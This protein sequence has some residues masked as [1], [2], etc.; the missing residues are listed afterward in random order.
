[1]S[2]KMKTEPFPYQAEEHA[3]SKD[4]EAWGVLW[5]QGCVDSETEYLTPSGWRRIDRYAGGPVGQW[6]PEDGKVTFVEPSEY[7]K[8]PCEKM[9]FIK[10]RYRLNQML[11]AEHRVPFYMNLKD[12][13]LTIAPMRDVYALLEGGKILGLPTNYT[14]KLRGEGCGESEAWLRLQTIVTLKGFQMGQKHGGNIYVYAKG[15]NSQR[16]KS[17]IEEAKANK[18]FCVEQMRMGDRF[19]IQDLIGEFDHH[20]WVKVNDRDRDIILDEAYN[21]CSSTWN[22]VYTRKKVNADFIQFLMSS[23]GVMTRMVTRAI[24][25]WFIREEPNV[26]RLRDYRKVTIR[27]V[28]WVGST[29]GFKYCFKV[30]TSFLLF[31]RGEVIF[32]SGNTGKSKVIVDCFGHNLY[33]GKVDAMVVIAPPGV[34]RNWVTDEI[35]R[36]LPDEI[37][38]ETMVRFYQ[39]KRAS[40]KWHQREMAELVAHKGPSILTMSYEA[41][42]TD[43]GKQV[44]WQMMSRR[45]CFAVLD[46]AQKIKSPKAKRTESIV[47]SGVY[48]AMRRIAT[49]TLG[50]EG[51]MDCFEPINFLDETFW[52]KHGLGSFPTFK[53][54]FGEWETRSAPIPGKFKKNG[55]PKMA[56]FEVCTEFKNLD[57]LESIM[58]KISTRVNKDVLGLPPKLYSK[59]YFEMN[60]EQKRA[61]K[62]LKEEYTTTVSTFGGEDDEIVVD[63]EMAMVRLLRLQQ[64]TCG[65]LSEAAGEPK[66]LLGKENPRLEALLDY[67]EGINHS[68]IIWARFIPD[69]DQIMARLGDRAVRYDGQV[70]PDQAQ[71][72]KE[73][74]QRG[75][76]QF[77]VG[78]PQK[79][80]TGLTLTIAKTVIYY[81]NSFKLEDRMQSEDRAHRIGTDGPV[82]YIDI[83]APETV[84]IRIVEALRGKYDIF[85]QINGDKLKGWI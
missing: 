51:P 18:L 80:A 72:A 6:H 7:V 44:H 61:Y 16:L 65:Y 50:A 73:T 77:F 19:L 49:G 34:E 24:G 46:E 74:F 2:Y 75:G 62:E 54:F 79:G 71:W 53:N 28:G 10:D 30:P 78:N 3:N 47:K 58:R 14:T 67:L 85:Q 42:M 40:T 20:W 36:H 31:R 35:P 45:K 25:G 56:F 5:E 39:S 15:S 69:I 13:K 23:K 26:H 12:R 4:E 1:M 29:D 63:A 11:S 59:L 55:D 60:S 57:K 70:T 21:W 81:S 38:E 37:R 32:P 33:S 9:F 83:I 66:V 8:K 52:K 64:V 82:N 84:D 27:N 43:R 41:Y 22:D 48:A 17:L 68:V 76:K